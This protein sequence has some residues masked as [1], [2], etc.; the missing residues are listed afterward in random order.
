MVPS[1]RFAIPPC[2]RAPWPL[3][4]AADADDGRQMTERPERSQVRERREEFE[5]EASRWRKDL[6]DRDDEA[7]ER[8]DLAS[9]WQQ[10]S[11]TTQEHEL[12]SAT[13]TSVD[14]QK[15]KYTLA[16]APLV[17]GLQGPAVILHGDR[18]CEMDEGITKERTQRSSNLQ[19]IQRGE[20][21]RGGAEDNQTQPDRTQHRRRHNPTKTEARA[22]RRRR[23][24]G[25][26]AARL[27][28]SNSDDAFFAHRDVSHRASQRSTPEGAEQTLRSA[29]AKGSMPPTPPPPASTPP[30]PAA[31]TSGSSS[32]A[33]PPPAATPCPQPLAGLAAPTPAP[34]QI[35]ASARWSLAGGSIASSAA[36]KRAT[37]VFSD[38]NLCLLMDDLVSLEV[39]QWMWVGMSCRA[40]YTWAGRGAAGGHALGRMTLTSSGCV[41]T[42]WSS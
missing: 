32:S 35:A 12:P 3:L 6:E 25:S 36:P 40:T 14:N 4:S 16:R 28:L 15:R 38:P 23:Q 19:L 13:L 5:K 8:N 31:L 18:L 33:P 39:R 37:H 17:M 29:E 22:D 2:W 26:K 34:T 21:M 30:P 20:T 10:Y 1:S 42:S 41:I 9:R 24:K 7:E 27:R 11:E